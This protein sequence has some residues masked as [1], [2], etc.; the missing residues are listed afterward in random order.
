MKVFILLLGAVLYTDA[1]CMEQEPIINTK[2]S[3]NHTDL[4]SAKKELD[5]ILK[6]EKIFPGFFEQYIQDDLSETM[7]GVWPYYIGV[8]ASSAAINCKT[9]YNRAFGPGRSSQTYDREVQTKY[10]TTANRLKL[11]K[12]KET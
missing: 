6:I 4:E 1:F 11:N 9:T 12:Y 7:R 8:Q 2:Y 10:G 3:I 5:E